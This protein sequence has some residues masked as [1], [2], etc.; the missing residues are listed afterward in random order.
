MICGESGSNCPS[1]LPTKQQ[2]ELMKM[3]VQSTQCLG[4]KQVHCSTEVINASVPMALLYMMDSN[5]P[6]ILPT[7]QLQELMTMAVETTQCLGFKQ[8]HCSIDI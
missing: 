3:A 2:Q 4:F 8:V 7:K 5:C 1:I 6:S